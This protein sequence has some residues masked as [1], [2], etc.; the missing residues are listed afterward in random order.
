MSTLE[1][2]KEYAKQVNN[3]WLFDKLDILELEIEQDK[4]RAK[5]EVIN[6]IKL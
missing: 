4:I 1:L 2:L 3:V 5:I 6:N